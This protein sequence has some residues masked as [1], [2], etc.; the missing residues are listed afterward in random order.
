MQLFT[1]RKPKEQHFVR[2][3]WDG[4][5]HFLTSYSRE[6]EGMFRMLSRSL[7]LGIRR[8]FPKWLT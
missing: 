3:H 6:L 2:D 1:P 4:T 7:I 8:I 5:C